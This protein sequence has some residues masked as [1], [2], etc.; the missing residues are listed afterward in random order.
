[1]FIFSVKPAGSYDG[2]ESESR[3]VISLDY[4]TEC[5]MSISKTIEPIYNAEKTGPHWADL[6]QEKQKKIIAD[7][8]EYKKSRFT[9]WTIFLKR[10]FSELYNPIVSW[11]IRDFLKNVLNHNS[12]R[13]E[14][15]EPISMPGELE[16]GD[17]YLNLTGLTRETLKPKNF[18]EWFEYFKGHTA[19]ESSL[20]E[21][22]RI[23]ILKNFDNEILL[24]FS[25]YKLAPTTTEEEVRINNTL[26]R[27]IITDFF[28]N[29]NI[30]TV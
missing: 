20:T 10:N 27:K 11:E 16:G 23:T 17:P 12:I 22:E 25:G 1:M 2:S 29:L 26:M 8:Y 18:Y 5:Q 24:A 3:W 13:R 28:N 19:W 6:T 15:A 14:A 21:E 9:V 7:C 30:F 4:P